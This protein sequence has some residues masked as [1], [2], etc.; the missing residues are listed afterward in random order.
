MFWVCVKRLRYPV[1]N[2][3]SPYS[4]LFSARID[5]IFSHYLINSMIFVKKV[6]EPKMCFDFSATF[7]ETFLI[8]RR[9]ERE[10]RKIL[11]G[12]HT[13]YLLLLYDFNDIWIFLA[14]R[15]ILVSNFTLSLRADWFHANR[16][17]GSG[18]TGQTDMPKRIVALAN[19]RSCLKIYVTS[20]NAK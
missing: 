13:K 20:P 14:F 17:T 6:V 2:D 3:H 7:S 15:K 9:T 19:L 10:W 5:S 18:S 4:R 1:C 11:I 16:R 12:L 8:L